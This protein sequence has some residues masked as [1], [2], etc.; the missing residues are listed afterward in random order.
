MT[1]YDWSGNM[2]KLYYATVTYV[3][4]GLAFGVFYREF[5]KINEYT[6][7]TML[8]GVHSH[9]ISLGFMFF[10]ILTLTAASSRLT[11]HKS[12]NKWFIVYNV[13]LLWT[14][15]TMAIRGVLEVKGSDIP[16]FNH[17]A[18]TGH[19]ILAVALVWFVIMLKKVLFSSKVKASV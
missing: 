19:T 12:F 11:E 5:T 13:G 17:M 16:G 10:L 18:G 14:T 15:I 8:S 7:P 4:L 9:L 3:V 1:N 6:D 2:K